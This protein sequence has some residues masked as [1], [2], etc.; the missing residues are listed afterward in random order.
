MKRR[1]AL[2]ASEKL[3]IKKEWERG[4]TRKRIA[5]ILGITPNHLAST[6]YRMNFPP[7]RRMSENTHFVGFYTT[8]ELD[9]AIT[10][11]SRAEGL[12][13]SDWLRSIVKSQLKV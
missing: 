1:D 10:L 4:T 7:K 5:E 3:L 9:R 13:K 11:I 2:R 8:P 6:I 12:S